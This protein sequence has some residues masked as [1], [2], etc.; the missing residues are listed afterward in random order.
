[1]SRAKLRLSARHGQALTHAKRP[2]RSSLERSRTQKDPAVVRPHVTR[3]CETPRLRKSTIM[4][5]GDVMTYMPAA[6]VTGAES[7]TALGVARALDR[8]GVPVYGLSSVPKSPCCRSRVW[9]H[10]VPVPPVGQ[11]RWLLTLLDMAVRLRVRA[12]LIPSQDELVEVISTNRDVLA[13]HYDFV[14]PTQD[15][16]TMMLDKAAFHV[17]ADALGL[18]V[19]ETQIVSTRRE[20][21]AALRRAD[22]PLILKP[23]LRTAEW[24]QRSPR[25]KA[26]RL[27]CASDLCS[28][29]FELF[30][31]ESRYMLQKWVSGMDSDVYFCLVYRNRSG[32]E[33]GYQVGRKLVQW[34]VDT[35][36][37]AAC[38]SDVDESVHRLT[39]SVFDAAGLVGLGSLEVKRDR[40]SG[41]W[42]I[43]EPTV[44]RPDLQSGLATARGVNLSM[45]AYLD[46][47][48]RNP[49]LSRPSPDVALWVQESTFPRALL[50]AIRKRRLDHRSLIA[51]AMHADTV[52]SAYFSRGDLLPLM[53][54]VLQGLRYHSRANRSTPRQ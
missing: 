40:E 34:P 52:A 29:P 12:V 11:N 25:E 48:R 46:A 9:R 50:W 5:A 16:V 21:E 43:T 4:P 10:I 27:S 32:R 38:I 3:D 31:G 41:R 22:F 19:P 8:R 53:S 54:E 37:T 6:V 36:S 7:P 42:Y 49:E 33:L 30:D 13:Q 18:P 2:P 39:N 26:F 1:V 14:L 51:S 20:L 15:T 17:W 44:G 35:G 47:S 24:Q 23:H 45:M 28:L